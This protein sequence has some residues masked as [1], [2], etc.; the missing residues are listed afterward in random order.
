MTKR[1][2]TIQLRQLEERFEKFRVIKQVRVPRAGWVR[3]LRQAIGMSTTQLAERMGV[4]RQAVLQ[5][6]K[7]EQRQTATWT[8]LRRAADAMDCEVVYAIIPRG[9]LRQLLMRQGRKQAERQLRRVAH[10]MRLDSQAVSEE[11]VERQLEEL[12]GDL[13]TERSR[14]LWASEPRRERPAPSPRAHGR[15]RR[16]RP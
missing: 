4:T 7:A 14:G 2:G 11:E 1:L 12:A 16:V 8:S 6:E 13:A 9:S 15:A 3:T 10:L 5:L